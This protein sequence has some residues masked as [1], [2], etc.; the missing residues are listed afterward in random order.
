MTVCRL[1]K[2]ITPLNF[3]YIILNS[4]LFTIFRAHKENILFIILFLTRSTDHSVI[5]SDEPGI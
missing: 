1:I 5:V 2:Y 3:N 4:E